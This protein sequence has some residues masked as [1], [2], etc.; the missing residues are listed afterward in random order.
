MTAVIFIAMFLGSLL[1]AF[2]ALSGW[3]LL[4]AFTAYMLCAMTGLGL[5][6]L[7]DYLRPTL[8]KGIAKVTSLHSKLDLRKKKSADYHQPRP[9]PDLS[10]YLFSTTRK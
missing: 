6:L 8:S 2:I 9:V 4:F 7:S 5:I 3:P 1:A 10:E